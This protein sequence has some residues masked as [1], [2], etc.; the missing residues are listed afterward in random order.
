MALSR[1]KKIVIHT[2]KAIRALDNALTH[3]RRVE[4]LAE[5]KSQPINRHLP[6]VVEYTVIL[7]EAIKSFRD[8]I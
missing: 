3:F 7:Q 5:G 2:N 6:F 8:V 1:R 4:E